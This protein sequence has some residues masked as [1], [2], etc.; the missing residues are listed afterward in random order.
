MGRTLKTVRAGE[1]RLNEGIVDG[2]SGTL[3]VPNYGHTLVTT[4]DGAP[5]CMAPPEVGVV[6]RVSCLGITTTSATVIVRGST[7]TSV[8]F[9]NA[10]ATQLTFGADASTEAMT[11]G[12]V[13][14]SSVKWLIT[15]TWPVQLVGQ[16]STDNI[17]IG[18]T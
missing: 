10:G 18:T 12:L 17:T 11:V 4:A 14:L 3:R 16:V 15:D 2:T 7:G 13:G 6:K 9:N 1:S 5:I 8:T